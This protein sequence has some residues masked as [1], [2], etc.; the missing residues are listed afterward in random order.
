VARIVPVGP[1][2]R[3]Y[4]ASRSSGAVLFSIVQAVGMRGANAA[5]PRPDRG[6]LFCRSGSHR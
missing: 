6:Q 5:A 2:Y 1:V 3:A 4:L